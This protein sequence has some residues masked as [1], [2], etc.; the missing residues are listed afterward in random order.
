MTPERQ[1]D[2]AALS[3]DDALLDEIASTRRASGDPAAVL[4]AEI[5]RTAWSVPASDEAS[6]VSLASRRLRRTPYFGAALGLAAVAIGGGLSAAASPAPHSAA[7]SSTVVVTG[8]GATAVPEPIPETTPA[9]AAT[10]ASST[11][12]SPAVAP[13]HDV[14]AASRGLAH[15]LWPAM[16]RPHPSPR[17]RAGGSDPVGA[18]PRAQGTIVGTAPDT[19]QRHGAR[20][21]AP[22]RGAARSQSE[23]SPEPSAA[24]HPYPYPTATPTPAPTGVDPASFGADTSAQTGAA[25]R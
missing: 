23:R 17:T 18:R 20:G 21:A 1:D 11:D 3:R 5:A 8:A 9:H 24:Q 2:P 10:A 22:H 13:A 14:G 6:V 16:L 19:H 12:G 7:S 15:S 25:H 4:L